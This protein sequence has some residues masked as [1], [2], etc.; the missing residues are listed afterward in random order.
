MAFF[1]GQEE[2]SV[3]SKGRV[4][5]PYKMRKGLTGETNK[6]VINRGVDRCVEVYPTETWQIKEELLSKLNYYNPD[7]RYLLRKMLSWAED[8]TLDSQQRITIP[9]RLIDYAGIKSNVIIMGMGDHIEIWD[10][11]IYNDYCAQ[12]E[13][14]KEDIYP[15]IAAKVMSELYNE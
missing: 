1:K 11:Q 6:F 12:F 14:G 15:E 8:I 10:P 7:K 9:K 3:D 2:Y 13:S 4:N 5:F